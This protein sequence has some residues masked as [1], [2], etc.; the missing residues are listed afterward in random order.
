MTYA[1]VVNLHAIFDILESEER[2]PVSANV[3]N[4]C[5]MKT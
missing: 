2:V 4:F 5:G 1:N 3:D